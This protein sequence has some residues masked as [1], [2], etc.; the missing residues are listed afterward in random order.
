MRRALGRASLTR[1]LIILLLACP[2]LPAT[3]ARA[4]TVQVKLGVSFLTDSQKADLWDRVDKFARWEA[5]LIY[6]NRPTNIVRRAVAAV[7]ACVH[8]PDLKQVASRFRRKLADEQKKLKPIDCE[9]QFAQTFIREVH[10][11]A[12]ATINDAAQV[13]RACLIC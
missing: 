9:H 12:D 8:E 7:D 13:C 5:R 4:E 3:T 10:E 11:L 2:A 1:L 6:C